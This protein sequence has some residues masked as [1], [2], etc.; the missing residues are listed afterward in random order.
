M[1]RLG[2]APGRSKSGSHQSYHRVNSECRKLVGVVVLGKKEV[3]KGT[4][5]SILNQLDISLDDFL[6][7]LR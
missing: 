1:E 5:R 3:P 4:L 2:C 7:S 6:T